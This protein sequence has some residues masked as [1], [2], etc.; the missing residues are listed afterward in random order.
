MAALLSACSSSDSPSVGGTSPAELP[1]ARTE[2]AGAA[3]GNSIYVAGGMTEDGAP[4]T[5]VDIYDAA[6]N[7]WSR[8]PSLQR[9]LHHLAM[10]SAQGRVWVIGGYTQGNGEVADVWSIEPGGTT[11][12]AEPSLSAPRGALSATVVNDTIV[13]IGGVRAGQVLAE[14]SVLRPGATSWEPGPS[15][16]ESREHL[17][18]TSIDGRVYAIAGRVSSLESNKTAVESWDLKSATWNSAPPLTKSRGGTAAS[19]Q[20]VAGGEEPQGTI[21]SVECLSSDGRTW[22][23]PFSL[24]VPR[25]GLAVVALNGKLHVI[26]GGE[27][28]GLFVSRAHEVFDIPAR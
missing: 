11:W 4:S 12:R 6:S 28:P 27:K 22:S 26:A 10:T 3:L 14:V 21:A 7:E 19:G 1:T 18:T 16:K 17:A 13:A 8:G 15:L 20:C 5:A 24:N 2:V 23:T 9:P 25:H